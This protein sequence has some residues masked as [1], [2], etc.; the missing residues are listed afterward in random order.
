MAQTL[1]VPT[2][3]PLSLMMGSLTIEEESGA[4]EMLLSSSHVLS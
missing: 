2:C 3:V 1:T 4:S